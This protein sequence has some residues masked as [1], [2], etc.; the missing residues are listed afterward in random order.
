LRAA[1]SAGYLS[2][3][4]ANFEVFHPAE[5]TLAPMGVKFGMPNFT[6]IGATIRVQ[7]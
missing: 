5:A 2:Y 4:E 7:E 3:S 1:Q 6:S